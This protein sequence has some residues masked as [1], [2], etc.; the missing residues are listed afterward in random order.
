VCS[1]GCAR[2]YAKKKIKQKEKRELIEAKKNL[3]THKDYL[4]ML[5]ISFNTYIRKRDEGKPCISCNNILRG[6]FDA[7]HFYSV[8]GYPNVRFNE[9]NVWGQCVH[10]NQHR[11][12]NIHEY[13]KRLINLIG[14]RTFN[15]L[16][17]EAHQKS[18]KLTVEE[19]KEKIK[20]YK[21]K[22]KQLEKK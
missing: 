18:N 14:H 1:I 3:L 5:Q 6:K 22:T 16:E 8:G 12:G 9:L 11:H 2:D 4:K 7:G 10:C 17:I 15:D 20:Y 19:I 21:L 13:A